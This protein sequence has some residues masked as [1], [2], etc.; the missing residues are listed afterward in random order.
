[1]SEKSQIRQLRE[2]FAEM[3]K[4]G[5][6]AAMVRRVGCKRPEEVKDAVQDAALRVFEKQVIEKY[7][8]DIQP[9]DSYIFRVVRSS[10]I[11]GIR[12]KYRHMPMKDRKPLMDKGQ[13]PEVFLPATAD[14]DS[15]ESQFA[16]DQIPTGQLVD[17]QVVHASVIEVV[18]NYMYFNEVECGPEVPTPMGPLQFSSLNVW[19]LFRS[20]YSVQEISKMFSLKVARIE[21]A[22]ENAYLLLEDYMEE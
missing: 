1:M 13:T 9:F 14:S 16:L 17:K 21:E 2:Q 11:D 5:R 22:I 10:V 19:K 4:S 15:G 8:P 3:V 12:N 7:N 18:E 6:I 20:G